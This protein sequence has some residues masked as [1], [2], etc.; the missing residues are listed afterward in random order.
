MRERRA[1]RNQ[2]VGFDRASTP[3]CFGTEAREEERNGMTERIEALRGKGRRVMRSRL[4]HEWR[5]VVG[6][7]YFVP[8]QTRRKPRRQDFGVRLKS[9]R[10]N[11][12]SPGQ[13]S[14]HR[15]PSIVFPRFLLLFRL[16]S[17]SR[18]LPSTSPWLSSAT[19]KHVAAKAPKLLPFSTFI[20]TV[21]PWNVY[22]TRKLTAA[23]SKGGGGFGILSGEK[24]VWEA[25]R[26]S[27]SKCSFPPARILRRYFCQH[28]NLANISFF[29]LENI[30][31][32]L[33][34]F[35]MHIFIAKC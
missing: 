26:V 14:I 16:S 7:W 35:Y 12:R 33:I 29:F 2:A 9:C 3:C 23:K 24:I 27:R 22:G 8:F 28:Y 34:V 18:R 6:G 15:N 13:S 11:L 25:A 30:S 10:L 4:V 20:L 32:I 31:F 21:G 1:C 17:F 5:G 19:A